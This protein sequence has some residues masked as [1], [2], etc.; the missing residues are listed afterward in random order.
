MM[1]KWLILGVL[2]ISGILAGETTVARPPVAATVPA[3]V[4]TVA[5][6]LPKLVDLGAK[7]CIP[8]KMMAPILEE[9]T[10]AYSGVLAVEFID[11][12]DPENVP[13]AQKYGIGSIPTQIFLDA[14]GKELWRNEGF[15]SKEDILAKWKELGYDL[16]KLKKDSPRRVED[17]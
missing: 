12:W 10:A 6:K 4:K 15:I 2:G 17:K 8:C 16:E 11:V 5:A 1:K 7:K 9:L 14:D 13:K 3:A